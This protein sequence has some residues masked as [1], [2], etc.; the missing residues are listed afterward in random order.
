MKKAAICSA[1]GQ[2]CIYLAC[3]GKPCLIKQPNDKAPFKRV[4]KREPSPG[5]VK[6]ATKG[7]K[8]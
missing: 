2:P 3:S 5:P 1:T 7:R 6:A 4:S 8:K